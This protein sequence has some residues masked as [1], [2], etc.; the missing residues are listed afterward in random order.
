VRRINLLPSTRKRDTASILA[1]LDFLRNL[2][3]RTW[4]VVLAGVA[5]AIAMLLVV[6]VSS[7]RSAVGSRAETAQAQLD[8]LRP[9]VVEVEDLRHLK[10]VLDAKM[11]V[12]DKLIIGR[13]CWAR[14]LNQ[15]A[16]VFHRDETIREKVWLTTLD[17]VE[18]RSI[19]TRV[20]TKKGRGGEVKEELTRVPVVVRAVELE[21]VVESE[22]AAGIVSDLMRLIREDEEFF[23]SFSKI[24]LENIGSSRGSSRAQNSAG[25]SFKL[26]LLMK[27]E[28]ERG[29]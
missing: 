13:L 24:E 29:D 19:E 4:T 20:T 17:L 28:G 1:R 2:P 3:P 7:E 23:M 18:R 21:G 11:D 6:T 10:E 14:L 27:R 15:L 16:A 5:V 8:S 9:V 22:T 12:V 25:K 26:S